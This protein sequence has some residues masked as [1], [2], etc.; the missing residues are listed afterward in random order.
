MGLQEGSERLRTIPGNVTESQIDF[1]V[2]RLSERPGDRQVGFI[3]RHEESNQTYWLMALAVRDVTTA[4]VIDCLS[5]LM[6]DNDSRLLPRI[7]I[8]YAP[9]RAVL[10]ED[11]TLLDV[12]GKPLSRQV[13]S[14][15]RSVRVVLRM[16]AEAYIQALTRCLAGNG[17]SAGFHRL[18]SDHP[19]HSTDIPDAW[20]APLPPFD[21]YQ[22]TRNR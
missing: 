14:F 10:M 8:P 5:L 4:R 21:R 18:P 19:F 17:C 6:L 13:L 20:L 2:A 22:S 3:L 9:P 11:G 12:F 7:L 1:V 16:R 15:V